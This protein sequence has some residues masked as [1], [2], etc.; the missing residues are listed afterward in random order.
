MKK[1]AIK[2]K[3]EKTKKK[4]LKTKS[5]LNETVSE[6][7]AVKKKVASKPADLTKK[8]AA[9]KRAIRKPVK[10]RVTA[11]RVPKVVVSEEV[12][13]SIDTQVEAIMEPT[14]EASTTSVSN[15]QGY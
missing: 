8:P 12:P 9:P 3:L 4:L 5:K 14:A 11:V 15:G 13:A 10:R 6:L 1:K 7:V 2:A